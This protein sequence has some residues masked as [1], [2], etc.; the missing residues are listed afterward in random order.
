MDDFLL[1]Q[2]KDV[3]PLTAAFVCS[4]MQ[5][6]GL[7]ISWRKADLHCALD[8][9]GWR[10]NFGTGAIYLQE[11]K[12]SKLLE[13]IS[14]MLSHPRISK[15]TLEKFLGLALWITQIF[16]Q[17]RSSLHYLF[18]DLH[19]IDLQALNTLLTRDIGP[20]QFLVLQIHCN[21]PRDLQARPFQLV[22]N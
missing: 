18:S 8:W 2:R 17:M 11:R 21:F 3:L 6:F 20:L 4:L 13:L 10:F 5:V 19:R 9:I 1:I 7:P 15:K 16:P 12:R 14:Q 22:A